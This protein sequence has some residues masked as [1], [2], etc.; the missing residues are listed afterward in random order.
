MKKRLMSIL[1][2]VTMLF[3]L[4]PAEVMAVVADNVTAG[5]TTR[6]SAKTQSPFADVREGSWYYD[7]V[8]YARV[9]GFFSGAGDG[10]FAPDGTMSRG[11]F[12][13]VL[14]RM[15][16]MDQAAYAG[17]SAFSDVAADAYYASFVAWASKHGITDGVGE[18]K[19]D[20]DGLINREQMA[21]F[22]VRYF[23]TFGVEYDT[24]AGVTTVPVDLDAVSPWA[25]EMVQKL[26]KAGLLN[27]DGVSF[28]PT[29]HASRA[30]AATLCMRTDKAVERWYSEPGVPSKRVSI[31]PDTAQN[32]D[33]SPDDHSGGSN[34]TYY[35]VTFA[36]DSAREEKV[37][38]K[39]TL[40]ST[41]PIPAQPAEKVFLGW[42]RDAAMTKPVTSDDKLTANI[43]LYAK[44]AGAVGLDEG[45]TPNFVSALDQASS[46]SV[47]VKSE[48]MP[49]LGT[50]FKFRN[51]TAP[52]KTPK[53]GGAAED[54]VNVETVKVE[55]GSGVWT[56]S[57]NEIGGF[58]AGH[59][60]Q[61]EL[62]T[63][64]VIYDDSAAAF[65]NFK[66][67]N[68]QYDVAAVRFFNFTIEKDGTL[69]LKLNE[70]IEFIAVDK[71]DNSE[72]LMQSAGL[73]RADTDGR[74]N[75]TYTQ[76][77]GSGSFTYN[78]SGDLGLQ[79]GDTVCIYAGT[80]PTQRRPDK[81]TADT[82]NGDATYVTITAIN[83]KT[84]DYVA[85][86]AEDVIFTPDVLPVDVD[87]EENTGWAAG[88]SSVSVATDK[89]DF[90]DGKYEKMGLSGET[91]VDV[92]D[93]LAFY[94]GSFGQ[95]DA[96]DEAYGEI[97]TITVNG[98]GTTTIAYQ[99]A[100]EEQVMSAME[101]YDET[102]LT[103]EELQDVIDENEDAIRQIIKAQLTGGDF[104]DDAGEYLAGLA[105]QT[106][107]VKESLGDGL[108][109][110]DC[111]ITY[112]DGT[113]LGAED[114]NLM[115]NIIDNEQD[116]KKPQVSFS[117]SP[118]LSH[119]AQNVGGTGIRV[120]VAVS[121]TFKIQKSGSGNVMEVSL[122]AFF[123]QEVTIGFSVSGGAVWKKKWI[124][125]YIA[126]YRM[127][128]NLDLGTYT[129]IGIT[130]TAKLTE[131]KK[132]WGMPWPGSV[133]EAEKT[134]KIF[135]LSESI[136]KEM[137]EIE[138]VLP[139]KEATASGGLAEKY[140]AF[141]E[142]ANEDWVDLI[143]VNL[144][145][146][147]G[148]VDP[149]HILAYGLE[150][151]FVV[152]ANLNVALGMTFQYE[153]LKRHS[154]SLSVKSKQADSD[155]VDL[156]T[157]GYQFDFYVMGHLGLRAG[158]RAKATV[159]LFSTKLAGVGLQ[160]EA[161]AYA[162]LWGY[163]YYHLENWKIA[164]T[165]Q[166]ESN[167]SGAVLVEIG[168]YLDV[169]FIAEALNGKYSY[170]PTIY[171]NE[172]P[173][174][175][176]GQRESVYD[177]AYED[178]PTY[179]ILNVTTYTL[180]SAVYDMYWMDLKTGEMEEGGQNN[181]KNFDSDTASSGIHEA[182]FAV[183]LSNPNFSYNPVNNQI[184]VNTSSGAV[185]QSCE[186]TITWKGAPMA[187]SSEVLR[188]TVTLNW[189]NDANAA[190]IA[191]E[192]NGGSPVQMLRL[193]TG[194]KLSGAMPA[195]PTRV[196][197]TFAGWYTNAALTTQFS[198]ANMPAD[199]TTLYAKWTPNIVSYTVEH[200]Q[201]ELDGRY[202]LKK[203]DA[204]QVGA[205]GIQTAAAAESYPGFTAQPV[206]QQTIAPDGSTRVA[207]YYDRK[208]YSLTFVYGNGGNDVTASV[209]YGS[210]IVIPADPARQG[211]IFNGWDDVIPDSMPVGDRT[212][213]ALWAAKT[214][215]PYTVKHYKQ[216]MDGSYVLEKTEE[217]LGITDEQTEAVA[218]AYTG[219]T[220]QPF[221]Q[222]TITG[223][224]STVVEIRYTLNSYSVTWNA[225]G[226]GSLT[227]D[228]TRGTVKYG[229]PIV[230]PNEPTR[231][232][233]TFGGWYQDA[234]L[235][236]ML[237]DN[238]TMPDEALTLYARWDPVKVN[239]TVKHFR[240]DLDGSYPASGGLVETQ[241]LTGFTAQ[242]TAAVA[243]PYTG[244]TAQI[245]TQQ[246][247]AADGS[248]VVEIRY[249]RNTYT[250]VFNGNG[251]DGGTMAEQAFRYG[252][253]KTLTAN[254]FT[255]AGYTFIGWKTGVSTDYAD[256]AP[257]LNLSTAANGTVTLYAQWLSNTCTVTFD[258]NKGAGSTQPSDPDPANM[259]ATR[260][261]GYGLLP[262]VSRAGYTFVG[263]FTV[264]IGGT[265]VTSETQV[266][267]GINHT[268]YAR[269]T[270]NSYT[271][272]FNGNGNTGGSMANQ[273]F[274]YD[275]PKTLTAGSFAKSGYTF[276][277]WNTAADGTGASYADKASVA[278]LTDEPNGTVT[279]WA[280]WAPTI[281]AA[282][283][284]EATY[285]TLQEAFNAVAQGQTVKLLDDITLSASVTT[286]GT[287][288][289]ILDLNGKT[290][291]G[292]AEAAIKNYGGQL[293]IADYSGGGTITSETSYTY[294]VGTITLG[295]TGSLVVA[296]GTV[297]NTALN[298]ENNGLPRAAIGSNGTGAISIS[299]GTVQSVGVAINNCSTASVNVSG[300]TVM[301]VETYAIHNRE[302][303]KITVSGTAK[304]TSG[305][306][307]NGGTIY[308]AKGAE[309]DTILEITGGTIENAGTNGCAIRRASTASGKISI[310]G[311][312][313]VIKGSAM[314]MNVAPDLS[315]YAKLLVTAS[316]D[317]N[318]AETVPYNKDEITAYKYLKFS[319]YNVWVGGV[320]VTNANAASITG[321]NISGTVSYDA[322]TNTLTLSDANI[323]GS[324][325][326]TSLGYAMNGDAAA[327]YSEYNLIINL[328]GTNTV[329][330]EGNA[331]NIYGIYVVS[332]LTIT[333]G[334]ELT[335]STE[336]ATASNINYA[337][338]SGLTGAHLRI[339][340]ATVIARAGTVANA[341]GKSYGII[342]RPTGSAYTIEL[343]GTLEVSGHTAA[344]LVSRVDTYPYDFGAALSFAG[345]STEYGGELVST[346]DLAIQENC[347][348]Y[349]SIKIIN[350]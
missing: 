210:G 173:F 231:V 97:I 179:S 259:I 252:E 26:W 23:E 186:M 255:K 55:G 132:P 134:K 346:T 154:F 270:A 323:S 101:L 253:S 335:V 69:N 309:T 16:G 129:G 161:G 243:K 170:A 39:D 308:L 300:G 62:I 120:E 86:E 153:N 263:W 6:Q 77:N 257:V 319:S 235:T 46:F 166:K 83:G 261:T 215:M 167:Y 283:I 316:K 279:L 141:M 288:D 272:V 66:A 344:L 106:D 74:G 93:Y 320:E 151:D 234:A 204:T 122:T 305:A 156:S 76:N 333:G 160:I 330:N 130:A 265:E 146:L 299:G 37:Y 190:T 280:Q 5:N 195:N 197:Y 327:I 202:A 267:S 301:S 116:G 135:N 275:S 108:T 137:E 221:N 341:T 7:A 99:T 290:L 68:A 11:M 251:S 177:F 258:S 194:T 322:I 207:V 220:A 203:T 340:G 176:A 297:K 89:L 294:F 40:L 274:T 276:N 292:G 213:T 73:Y 228:Y 208:Y 219:F 65:G 140:A 25:R 27:G 269:W 42:Y 4:L 128:G 47:T 110:S 350:P 296:G 91:T 131:D 87:A 187:G 72:A 126:D 293:T 13:T 80:I 171:A 9:N 329:T 303:G 286:S 175:S 182:R 191:F 118:R 313:P 81:G 227:G 105:L 326:A 225:N 311:G 260:G 307:Y 184:T 1:L 289:F 107:E 92:G 54:E 262:T 63:D 226:A 193:L 216:T 75:T 60:Y 332:K 41:M 24:G 58:T 349:K 28:Q 35:K 125:P 109:M 84:Y 112:A 70:D 337:I 180:P 238:A 282:G 124:F 56:I 214:D 104:F 245:I 317:I 96:Q 224:G 181:V 115:G 188:R 339:T 78:G 287:K 117:I 217:K 98:D 3:T 196:G 111:I 29:D 254:A 2:L 15:A 306:F 79:V 348:K 271:V 342:V 61:I 143:K 343:K 325:G 150:V 148:G 277:G 17:Q 53:T 183:E 239:Y 121:Y 113:P 315:G 51:I 347:A 48:N 199:N 152:S 142:D 185:E 304:I 246:T 33:P 94:T 281:Y 31:D 192:S 229:T 321:E 45:G 218:D 145:S 8:Q 138:T 139:E 248:T 178:D 163:F 147:R 331:D 250:V 20:P 127:N 44:F 164:G 232:G 201:K 119:F 59:T 158:I 212:F 149:F 324:Y 291:D 338:C 136:K 133:A 205:V 268:L 14:G 236:M 230:K 241:S 43:T 67:T 114:L 57:S 264:S 310:L 284:G 336:E 32:P 157:N 302:T 334:G 172:W 144:I 198:F 22:L 88:G 233:Y 223:G 52:E 206:R 298:P 95:A 64:A 34:T 162:R 102:Q 165:W 211:Y 18:G 38:Q 189:S 209:P 312:S 278:N 100:T 30:Q 159:G 285:I 169:K 345:V 200:Y 82:D 85:A 168:V 328:V 273:A 244:F 12:V 10:V 242:D 240:Q 155:T 36:I 295:S 249:S 247:I 256:G 237:E 103:E 50:D 314:A 123:E 174:W 90:S 71:V 318:V 222:K 19:F 21:V 49:V 266:T